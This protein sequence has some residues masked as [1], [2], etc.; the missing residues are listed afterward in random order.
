MAPPPGSFPMRPPRPLARIPSLVAVVAVLFLAAYSPEDC[1]G[2]SAKDFYR[3]GE[4]L[5]KSQDPHGA[6]K[7]FAEAVKLDARNKK[8]QWALTGAAN[9]ASDACVA[10]ATGELSADPRAA[11]HRLKSALD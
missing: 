2:K 5:L 1:Y 4:R 7:A 10:V 6:Y 9:S 3:E 8:Y 11:L